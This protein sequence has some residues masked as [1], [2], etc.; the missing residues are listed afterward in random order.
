MRIHS[1]VILLF[2]NLFH[3]ATLKKLCVRSL[4]SPL[5]SWQPQL[6]NCHENYQNS[7]L[8]NLD[9]WEHPLFQVKKKIRP[10]E[11]Q[12]N[13]FIW[14]EEKMTA[15]LKLTAPTLLFNLKE[16]KTKQTWKYAKKW[17]CPNLVRNREWAKTMPPFLFLYCLI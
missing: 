4:V 6:N 8:A 12:K 17:F 16:T 10:S 1:H 11:R 9:L 3:P 14:F 5:W 13:N 7:F 15:D 2:T